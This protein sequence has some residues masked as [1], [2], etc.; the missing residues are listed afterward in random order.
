M[1][2]ESSGESYVG[3]EVLK[4]INY[5]TNVEV[6]TDEISS[7][8]GVVL[9]EAVTQKLSLGVPNFPIKVFLQIL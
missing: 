4:E 2:R 7:Y 6:D 8:D 9:E 5:I 1:E 3:F